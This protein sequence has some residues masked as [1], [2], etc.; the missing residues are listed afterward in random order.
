[1][2]RLAPA[3]LV[4]LVAMIAACGPAP[5]SPAS[6]DAPTPVATPGSAGTGVPG[7]PSAGP[8]APTVW[9]PPWSVEVDVPAEVAQRRPLPFCG[10]ERAPAPSPGEFIDRAVR[11]CFWN[12]H[13]AGTEAEFASVQ[14]TI[15]GA[16]IATIYR[17]AADGSVEV[18][19][20]FTQD[21]FGPGGWQVATCAE[22]VEGE[23]DA[24]LGVAGCGEPSD[25]R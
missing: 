21:P 12:A 3:R 25:L 15:E 7:S 20:D 22:V 1:M 19:T 8:A 13:L 18:L 16:P 23:G 5:A 4:V 6:P 9:L 14:T 24:L 17:L 10:L 11:L 2:P